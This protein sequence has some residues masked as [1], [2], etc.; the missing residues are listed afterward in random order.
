[1][2]IFLM[3]SPTPL[4]I[5]CFNGSKFPLSNF[6]VSMRHFG[7]I[8]TRRPTVLFIVNDNFQ[9][10][11]LSQ[12]KSMEYGPQNTTRA[13]VVLLGPRSQSLFLQICYR[14]STNGFLFR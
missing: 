6:P 13:H 2:Y 3:W 12:L 7:P 14:S 11:E 9:E 10:T 4:P 8:V 5:G 1:M